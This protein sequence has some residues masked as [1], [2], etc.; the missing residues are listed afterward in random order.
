MMVAGRGGRPASI[1]LVGAA[2]TL[3]GLEQ[4][5]RRK[6]A[7][8]RRVVVLRSIPLTAASLR[9]ITGRMGRFDTLV[10][11]SRAAARTF[12]AEP[13]VRGHLGRMSGIEVLAVG[14]GSA[15][16]LRRVG[17]APA[18][19]AEGG[20]RAAVESH[21][22]AVRP[23]RIL[24]PRSARAGSGLAEALRRQGHSV[25]DPVVYRLGRPRPIRAGEAR[26]I[27]HA[28]ILV[29]ASPSALSHLRAGLGQDRFR[30]L[31]SRAGLVVLGDRSARAA[32]GH[33]FRAVQVAPTTAEQAFT[34]FLLARFAR[35]T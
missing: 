18:W 27:F 3:P 17:L 30:R 31:R 5:L 22:L 6:R 7:M 29:V 14:P 32:R 11:T 20:G 35:A 23:R 4:Q 12:L 19:V 16:A 25:F 15:N 33:G 21:L 2:D 28:D 24:Y 1:V 9:R 26:L 34:R 8:L 10:V 13:N